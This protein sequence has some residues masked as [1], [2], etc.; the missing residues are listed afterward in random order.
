MVS[1]EAHV[2]ELNIEVMVGAGLLLLEKTESV[3]EP[4]SASLSHSVVVDPPLF[5]QALERGFLLK[6]SS[7]ASERL[8]S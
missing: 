3:G 2:A 8:R 6:A 1:A 7:S 4:N 5:R